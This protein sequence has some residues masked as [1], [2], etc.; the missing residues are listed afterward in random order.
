[1]VEIGGFCARPPC[2]GG[3]PFP[4]MGRNIEGRMIEGP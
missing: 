1:M 2:F 3:A 4:P